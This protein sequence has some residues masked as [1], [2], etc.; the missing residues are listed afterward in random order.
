MFLTVTSIILLLSLNLDKTFSEIL[1]ETMFNIREGIVKQLIL[2][3]FNR[4]E[5]KSSGYLYFLD[6]V[7]YIPGHDSLPRMGAE[8]GDDLSVSKQRLIYEYQYEIVDDS[9]SFHLIEAYPVR[10]AKNGFGFRKYSG[11]TP[12]GL[13]KLIN[14]ILADKVYGNLSYVHPWEISTGRISLQPLISPARGLIYPEVWGANDPYRR[15]VLLHGFGKNLEQQRDEDI[16]SRGCIHITAEG[17]LSVCQKCGGGHPCYIF[18]LGSNCWFY[19]LPEY[20]Q[21]LTGKIFRSIN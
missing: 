2:E 4:R 21:E 5:I 1:N 17:I 3:H 16:G 14:P 10:T 6:C 15:G 11:Q 8:R 13:Y 20:E 18:I 7:E 9:V 12:T 19:E